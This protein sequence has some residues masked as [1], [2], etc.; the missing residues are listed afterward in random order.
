MHRLRSAFVLLT[1]VVLASSLPGVSEAGK[2]SGGAGGGSRGG[3][4]LTADNVVPGPG[5][6][7]ASAS[8]TVKVGRNSVSF[9]TGVSNTAGYISTIAIYEGWA[10]QTGPVVVR[11]SPSEIGQP[12][13]L[14]TVPASTDVC[15]AISRNPAAY[16]VEIRTSAFPNGALRAQLH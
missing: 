6:T 3:L 14:G 13:L 15:R 5:D 12:Q 2:P 16:Y 1:L 7:G 4:K 11:L 9:S 8:M 10:G